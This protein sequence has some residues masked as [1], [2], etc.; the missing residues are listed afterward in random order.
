MST[1]WGW[2]TTWWGAG[3]AIVTLLLATSLHRVTGKICRPRDK[4]RSGTLEILSGKDDAKFEIIAV[5]GLGAHPYH[6]WEARKTQAPDAAECKTAQSSKIHLLKDLLAHDFPDAR[7]WNFAHESNWL[8]DAP[9]KTTEEIGK[10]LLKEIRDKRSSPHLPIIFIGHSLGGI[11]IKQALCTSDSQD[12]IDDTAGIIFLGA[13][14]QGSSASI[15]GAALAALTGFLGSDTTLLLSLKNHG[16]QLSNLADA[17]DSRIAPNGRRQQR[18]RIT[19][20]YETKKTYLLGLSL[21]VVVSRDS[22]KVHA[23]ARESHS[24]ETDHSGLN[25]CGGPTDAL[26]AALTAAIRRL[27]TPSLLEQ[28]DTW[29]RDKHYTADRLRI[30]RL[31]GESLPMDQCYI[32]LAIVERSGEDTG[33]PKKGGTAPSPFSVLARQKVEAPDKTMQVELAALFNERKGSDGGPVHPRRILIRGRAGVGKTTLCKKIVHEFH[34]GT[35]DKWNE[36]F[37]R[38][39][40]VPLRNLKLPERRIKPKYT[41]E[42]LFRH[43]FLLPKN[44]PNL[45]GALFRALGI[46]S[47]NTLFLLDGLDEVSQDLTGNGSM[48]RFLDELLSQPNVI[49]TSRPSAKPVRQNVHLELET[50]GFGP[51]QVDEYIEKSFTNP[52]MVKTDQT[53]VDKVQS[54]L[55]KHWLVQGLVRIPIQLDALCYTWEEFDPKAVPN[56]MTGMYNTIVQKLW[57]KD[58]VRLEKAKEG[59]AEVAHTAEIE[60]K[61]TAEIAL[62]ECLA[63][64]GLHHDIIDFTP[65]HRDGVVKL[66]P[67]QDLPLDETLSRLSFLRTS[68]TA[69]TIKDRNYHFIHLTFQEYFAAQYFV[70]QWKDPEGQ[71]S[72]LTLSNTNTRTKASH[73]VEFLRKHKYTT[74]YDIF[75]RF[76]AGL[77]DGSAQAPDF[78]DTIEE[79]PLDI[80]GPTHQRL[81]MHC[82]S[83]I[84]SN[85]ATRQALEERLARWLLFECKF[86]ES[87]WLASEAEIPEAALRSALLHESSDGQ[88]RL[89]RSLA[90]RALI[91][92]SI[93]RAVAARLGDE[94]SHVRHAAITALGGGVTLP[95]GMLTAVVALLGDQ[96]EFVRNAAIEAL[97]GRAMLPDGVLTAVAA[98]LEDEDSIVRRAAVET[99]RRRATLPD[100]VLKAVAARLEDED[101]NV[102]IASIKAL[103]GRAT[104]PN[105][106]LTAVVAQLGDQDEFVR[107]AAVMAL[108]GRATLP[109]GVLT[110]VAARLEDE[111]SIVRG[112]A[113]QALGGRATLPDGVLKAVAARLD[114]KDSNDEYGIVRRAAVEALIGRITLPDGMLTAVAALLGDKNSNVRMAAIETLGGRA[115]LPD[116]M[117]T[118]VAARLDDKD[119]NVRMAAV[120]ALGGRA[121]LPDVML[122]A[123]VVRLEDEDSNVRRAAVKALGRR[124]MLPDVMLTAVVVRLEDEYGIVRRAAVEALDGHATLFDGMLTAVAARLE[125]ED[126]YV[127]IA[128]VET[129]RK[130]ATLLDWVATA[131]A[132]RLED[133]DMYVRSAAVEALGERATLPDEVLMVVAARLEDEDGYVRS[134]A[135][136]VLI[137]RHENLSRTHLK[138]SLVASLYTT[139]LEMSFKEQL[140]WYIEEDNF[141]VNVPDSITELSI[142]LQQNEVIERING[143]RPADCPS[144][145]G[146]KS[147]SNN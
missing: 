49:I 28:A 40:W 118:A 133:E 115:M 120:E 101:T 71:L 27:K 84:S 45:A 136:K 54:F 80:L 4:N 25:K 62:V 86:N 37:D 109:D 135:A 128:A 103:G 48:P 112:A 114:D 34:K 143:A 100:G 31:S 106:V 119:W 10:C 127:R 98:R 107:N 129:L 33:H 76:V 68:D 96:D 12:I 122:T 82:L 59:Y 29:I 73:P 26:F 124:V 2:M 60:N 21:G 47:S 117:L 23:D 8:I 64:N 22:A 42:H 111:N 30:E 102:R 108:G 142:D 75:W 53:K 72:F 63:F 32:N 134:A 139:L 43:E 146:G 6:T 9:V 77:L 39:L 145:N 94:D 57:K 88:A 19:S 132:A 92:H 81:V 61:V 125:D 95:D 11:I 69:S 138:G 52:K 85:L 83:E 35:W 58:I 79:E 123:V 67:L 87:A 140:S 5:P 137:H 113:V 1:G 3:L 46:K 38:V 13:P 141:S 74:R 104:L 50:I 41:L 78:I 51:D 15:A 90:S 116:G 56:T 18:V 130:R 14:H 147:S 144:T 131:M 16:A 66:C 105:W 70:R 65:E 20:F 17:F 44:E 91:P 89:L 110:A 121:M 36:L 126:R 24:I 7:I 55:Q 99:L 93:A 97:G